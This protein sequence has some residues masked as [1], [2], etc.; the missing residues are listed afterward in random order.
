MNSSWVSVN[1]YYVTWLEELRSP[2]SIASVHHFQVKFYSDSLQTSIFIRIANKAPN[3]GF[4]FSSFIK[5]KRF[6]KYIYA[7]IREVISEAVGRALQ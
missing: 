7:N 1:C 3:S 2:G 5:T 6:Y 4:E